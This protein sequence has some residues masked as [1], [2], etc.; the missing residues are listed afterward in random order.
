MSHA[1]DASDVLNQKPLFAFVGIFTRGNSVQ[2]GHK[3]LVVFNIASYA[4]RKVRGIKLSHVIIDGANAQV[5]IST[6]VVHASQLDPG[7]DT[8]HVMFIYD[9]GFIDCLAT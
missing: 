9:D 3:C 5:D 6:M 8:I 7:H 1:L 4:S 2:F